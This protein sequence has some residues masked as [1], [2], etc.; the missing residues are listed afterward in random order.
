MKVMRFSELKYLLL[1]MFLLISFVEIRAQYVPSGERGEPAA[2]RYSVIDTNVIRSSFYN[3][4]FG[5]RMG[6]GQGMAYEWPKGTNRDYLALATMFVGGEVV[7]ANGDTIHIV[8]L[9]AFRNSPQGQSWN[10]EPVPQYQNQNSGQLARSDDPST[11]PAMWIDKLND[12]T[13]PGWPGSWN[14]LFGKNVFINGTELYYHFADNVYNRYRY[15][16]IPSDT[17]RRGLGIVVSQRTLAWREPFLEDAI[18]TVSD[19]FNVGSQTIL[20]AGVTM[21]IADLLGGDGDSQDDMIS[22]DLS[23]KTVYFKDRDGLSS[24]PAFANARVLMPALTFLR[25]P[26]A[27]GAELG[28]TNIQYLHAGGINFPTIA[29]DFFWDTFMRPGEYMDP[30]AIGLPGD[31]DAFVSSSYFSLPAQGSRRLV[32]AFVFADDSLNINRKVNY[33]RGLVGGGFTTNSVAVSLVSPQ[34]GQVLSGQVPV[35]W[36]AGAERQSLKLDIFCSSNAG[37]TWRLISQGESNDGSSLLNTDTLSDGIFYKIMLVAYDSLG[38]GYKIMDS[39][40]TINNAQQAPPQIRL[41]RSLAGGV[42]QLQVPVRWVAGDADGDPVTVDLSYRISGSESWTS[43]VTGLPNSGRYDLDVSSLPNSRFYNLRGS[44]TS[45]ALSGADSTGPFEIRNPRYG[46][47]ES[48]FVERNTVGTGLIQPHI[49]SPTQVTGH[50]YHVMF[51]GPSDS[52]TSYNVFDENTSSTVVSGATQMTGVVEGPLFDGIRLLVRTDGCQVD[53]SAT[54]WRRQ[55][56][57]SPVFELYRYDFEQGSREMKDYCV[58]IGNVGMDTSNAAFAFGIQLPSRFVN[59]TV[60]DAASNMRVPFAFL[61]IDGNDGRFTASSSTW[62][63]YIVLLR[64]FNP[65][66]LGPTWMVWMSP[67]LLA[68]PIPGDTLAIHL[69]KPFQ[70]EDT[71]RFTALAGGLLNVRDQSPNQ[72]TLSQNFPN[73]FNPQTEIHFSLGSMQQVE[74]QIYDIL[75]RMVRSLVHDRFDPG[76][77]VVRWDGKDENGLSVATGVYFYRLAAG[78]FVQTK[79]MVLLR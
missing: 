1:G 60:K 75:G 38:L 24:N 69:R 41:D 33:L 21:W 36:S 39:T 2:R 77:H 68:N 61:E 30:H 49:V 67:D 31:Y 32:T 15:Y 64:R 78:A 3:V 57:H 20:R 11:W 55:G 53:Q 10:F 27:G 13:D 44:V 29:D 40:C 47:S 62:S 65:D 7:D 46:L 79:K 6:V 22:Y 45:G 58:V 50:T 5:G 25:T 26:Q 12:P 34:P 14:G 28:M 37:D 63:D 4:G 48:A 18:V 19:I 16:P 56:I 42:W 52:A 54:G 66:S 74:L 8:S 71:Y 35:E 72:F 9:P 76:E 70:N 73:P 17:T 51:T 43:L 23:R 59:F